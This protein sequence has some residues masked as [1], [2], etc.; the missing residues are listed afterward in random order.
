MKIWKVKVRIPQANRECLKKLFEEDFATCIENKQEKKN[1]LLYAESQYGEVAL[2]VNDFT[3]NV[4]I[5]K[6]GELCSLH[7]SEKGDGRVV[8]M[9]L[10]NKPLEIFRHL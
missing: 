4:W 3:P 1:I 2:T 9:L 5:W 8:W 7:Q 10:T 6:P